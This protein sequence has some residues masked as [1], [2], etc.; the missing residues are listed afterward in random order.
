MAMGRAEAAE[1]KQLVESVQAL[2]EGLQAALE[3][4]EALEAKRKK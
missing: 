2:R 1:F 3:R 4:I